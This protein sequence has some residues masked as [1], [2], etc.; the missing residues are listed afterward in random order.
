MIL[1]GIANKDFTKF[2]FQWNKR[3]DKEVFAMQIWY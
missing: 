1:F 2:I 3:I